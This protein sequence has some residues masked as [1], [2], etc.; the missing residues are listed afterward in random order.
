[1]KQYFFVFQ[2]LN[3]EH[4][5]TRGYLW[6]PYVD[7][8]GAKHFYW[9]NIEKLKIGDVLLH[10]A[11]HKIV[12]ISIVID[13]CFNSIRS[14]ERIKKGINKSDIE[15]RKTEIGR[16]VNTKYIKFDK[17]V[18]TRSIISVIIKYCKNNK[19]APFNKEGKGKMG[20]I[21]EIS[22][23]FF[24]SLLK[25]VLNEN[26]KYENEINQFILNK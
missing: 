15:N 5:S 24:N 26:I 22:E 6:C 18:L 10:G 12:G 25:S 16:Q 17:P 9:D 8:R 20:Y 14:E 21:F 1:M 19:F 2:N 7:R 13:E 4:E 11:N 23:D 3:F